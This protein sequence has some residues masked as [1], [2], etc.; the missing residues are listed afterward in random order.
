M[1]LSSN[2]G[3]DNSW[4]WATYNIDIALEVKSK[5]GKR[6]FPLYVQTGDISKDRLAFIH[7]SERLKMKTILILRLIQRIDVK[8]LENVR[9]SYLS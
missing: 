2:E 8:K 5:T 3:Y 4:N 7:I 9:Q 1:K 6:I